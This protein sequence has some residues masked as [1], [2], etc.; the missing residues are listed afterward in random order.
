MSGEETFDQ[1]IAPLL[2]QAA[3][4]ARASGMSLLAVCEFDPN[5]YSTT[6]TVAE[7]A[8]PYTRLVDAAVRSGANVDKMIFELMRAPHTSM[9]LVALERAIKESAV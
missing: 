5:K 4:I 6:R 9:C 1:T 2:L 8:A 7:N 3:T